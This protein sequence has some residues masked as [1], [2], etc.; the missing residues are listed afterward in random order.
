MS[1]ATDA[2]NDPLNLSRRN[3]N[4]AGLLQ[5]P[6][7]FQV[8]RL[9]GPF[10]TDE[11]G[12]GR[13]IAHLQ[14][15]RGGGRRVALILAR[16]IVVIPLQRE[17]AKNPL[18]PN[19]FPALAH[20]SGLGLVADIGTVGGLLEQPADQRIGG[21]ENRRAHQHFQLGDAVPVQLLGLEAGDQLLDFFFL[22]EEDF[23]R[24]GFF[25]FA[26]A[27]FWRVSWTTHSA[28]CSV[29]SRYWA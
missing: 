21:F 11:L 28:Y 20:L 16:V 22:R 26:P 2:L 23:G 3:P 4:A 17:A 1:A 7:G 12:Q 8:G 9:G 25:F 18:H 29:S 10:Q 24:D 15:Q 5:M 14:T 13:R 19:R 6:L 27:M